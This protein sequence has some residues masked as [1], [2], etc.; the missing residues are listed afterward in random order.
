MIE[1]AKFAYSLL[2]RAF[3]KQTKTIEDQGKKCFKTWF[4]TI[5]N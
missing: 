2:E 1:Q 4:S 5:I 3:K